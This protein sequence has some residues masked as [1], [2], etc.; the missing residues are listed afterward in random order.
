MEIQT[1]AWDRHTNVAG[2]K[3]LMAMGFQSCL[4]YNWISNI[5]TDVNI[6]NDYTITKIKKHLPI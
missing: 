6:Q 4:S 3:W 1:M 5:N 2:L